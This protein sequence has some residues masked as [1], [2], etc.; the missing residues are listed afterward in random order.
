MNKGTSS[1]AGPEWPISA[2]TTRRTRIRRESKDV[3]HN[4]TGYS[5][6]RIPSPVSSPS[7]SAQH[8]ER[9]QPSTLQTA[10]LGYVDYFHV[11]K[12]GAGSD[13]SFDTVIHQRGPI[14]IENS[15]FYP[16][17]YTLASN[18]PTS[19]HQMFNGNDSQSPISGQLQTLDQDLIWT[20]VPPGQTN[21]APDIDG[22]HMSDLNF[23][24]FDSLDS[25]GLSTPDTA[26][27]SMHSE[28]FI[29]PITEQTF[30][31]SGTTDPMT[32]LVIS[33]KTFLIRL[34]NYP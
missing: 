6:R 13:S 1:Q 3:Y 16:V 18:A 9:Y 26:T 5:T 17:S 4:A 34:S 8:N 31:P 7:D 14:P 2:V 10:N 23:G 33:G 19:P 27:S 22:M 20:E 28:D 12:P 25:M 29:F 30:S 24:S 15:F 32:G 11:Q 21:M